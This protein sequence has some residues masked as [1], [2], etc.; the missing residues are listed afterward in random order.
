MLILARI[1]TASWPILL[2]KQQVVHLSMQ[3]N[4]RVST[5][6]FTT[7]ARNWENLLIWYAYFS[8]LFRNTIVLL[9]TGS[10]TVS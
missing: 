2:G 8:S 7:H 10:G 6:Q 4:N 9:D 5:K 3:Y 1:Q